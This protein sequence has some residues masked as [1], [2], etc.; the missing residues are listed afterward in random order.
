MNTIEKGKFM[1]IFRVTAANNEAGWVK[2][3]SWNT[4]VPTGTE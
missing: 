1:T 2:Y 4:P 3:I